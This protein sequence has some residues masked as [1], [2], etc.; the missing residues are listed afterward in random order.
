[1]PVSVGQIAAN[2]AEVKVPVGDDFVTVKYAPGQITEETFQQLSSLSKLQNVSEDNISDISSIFESLNQMLVD[3]IKSW[4]LTEEED[5][6]TV[7][8]LTV[9][10]LSGKVAGVQKIP[11]VFRL[12]IAGA[13]IGD[14]RPE[15]MTPQTS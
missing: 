3:L 9:E 10:R 12:Q 8:P 5:G 6:K 1:M 13:L 14:I 2:T 15:A 11:L 4:D 7:V